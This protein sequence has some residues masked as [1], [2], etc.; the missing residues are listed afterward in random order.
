MLATLALLLAIT[1]QAMR[2]HVNFLAS[3][4]LEGRA[5]GTRGY[6]V[7][8]AY[9]AAQFEAAGA[10]PAGDDGTYLQN[11][12]FR[13]F[14]VDRSKSSF[15]IDGAA[16][17]HG[18]DVLI[19]PGAEATLAVEA[20]VVFAGFGIVA[21]DLGRNDFEGLDV[22]GKIVA[23]LLGAPPQFPHSQRAYY[24]SGT[25]KLG[26]AVS[27]GAAGTLFIRTLDSERRFNWTRTLAEADSVSLRALDRNG[28]PFDTFPQ[29][30]G[31]AT[32]GPAAAQ[33]LF[34][35]ETQSLDEILAD[36]EKGIARAYPLKKRVAIQT[37][38]TIGNTSSPNVVAIVRG[39][40]LPHEHVVV[41]AH[42]DH[43]GI[44]PQGEDRI[45]NGALDN[46]SGIAALLEI[47]RD[48][49]A[50][51]PRPRRSIVF[52]AV[53]AE[54]KG[55]QGSKAFADRPSV[56]GT[57]VA[58][59][60][61]DMITMLFPMKSLVALGI[62]HSSL[63]PLAREAAERN[64]FVVQDDPLPEE[65]RFIRSDQY[66]FVEKGI[67]AISY[68]GGLVSSDPSIDGEKLTR[69]WLRTVYHTV[70]DEPDQKL[71]YDSGARWARTNRDLAVLIANAPERPRWNEGDFFG[72]RFARTRLPK[73]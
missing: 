48:V 4:A 20:P 66:S 41:S 63:G 73:R 26:N 32:L 13:T 12:R 49:A 6:D 47:A 22:R 39:S 5:A 52:A 43:V 3:D 58:N 57:I 53:T 2:A 59:V 1:P 69:E 55:L 36:A 14:L 18:R 71:D 44:A 50:T 28:Q 33:A 8:A 46:A 51:K 9:V 35:G 54:E 45:R 42:L 27:R 21:P 56:D 62:E 17:A 24:S 40:E 67:P 7:A 68:K 25:V 16:F 15:R 64:A 29:L 10:E 34:A 19:V 60:N 37:T 61:M 30:R 65:V 70:H 72:M 31:R 23:M 38:T 11:V